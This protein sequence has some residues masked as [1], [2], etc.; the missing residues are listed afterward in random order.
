MTKVLRHLNSM[1]IIL[2]VCIVAQPC[3]A[4]S[5][6]ACV[7]GLCIN[8]ES[9]TVRSIFEDN[10]LGNITPVTIT[11]DGRRL[12]GYESRY[13]KMNIN[14]VKLQER[15]SAK[16]GRIGAEET[17]LLVSEDIITPTEEPYIGAENSE[18]SIYESW[19]VKLLSR[20]AMGYSGT[21]LND[22]DFAGNNGD[23]VGT[24]STYNTQFFKDRLVFE[25][26]NR[27][28]VSIQADTINGNVLGVD[29]RTTRSTRYNLSLKSTGITAFRYRQISSDR[30]HPRVEGEERYVGDL[31]LSDYSILMNSTFVEPNP[32]EYPEKY[33]LNC[34]PCCPYGLYD[35]LKEVDASR[36][37][38]CS[39]G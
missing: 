24:S 38:D 3:F 34:Y 5:W 31:T 20:R 16:E 28:N 29:I 6:Y 11:P 23:Y 12:N 15:T 17:I 9:L 25:E 36:I 35:D 30:E 21:G 26:L 18:F 27:T 7:G 37:F 2:V 14:D 1:C 10:L 39:Q 19:P 22:F 4:S 33:W 32:D 8:R 13:V